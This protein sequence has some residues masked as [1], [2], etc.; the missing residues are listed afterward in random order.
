MGTVLKG[1]VEAGRACTMGE[2]VGID[3]KGMVETG[4]VCTMEE[5]A[6]TDQG[7]LVLWTVLELIARE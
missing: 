1:M 5:G 3:L 7:E 6:G 4:R 2:G